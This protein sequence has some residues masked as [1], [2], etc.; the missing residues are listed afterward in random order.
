MILTVSDDPGVPCAFSEGAGQLIPEA[1]QEVDEQGQSHKEL[2]KT[3]TQH[4]G[5]NGRQETDQQSL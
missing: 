4:A 3:C 1:A 5:N 2:A